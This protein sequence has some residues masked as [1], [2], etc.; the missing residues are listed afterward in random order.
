MLLTCCSIERFQKNFIFLSLLSGLPISII[1]TGER[2][3]SNDLEEAIMKNFGNLHMVFR[4]RKFIAA[5][6]LFSLFVLSGHFTTA[7]GQTRKGCGLGT[8]WDEYEVG[9]WNG[10][11]TR[12]GNSSIFDAVYKLNGEPDVNSILDISV[13]GNSV[14]IT[15]TDSPSKWAISNCSYEGKI[16]SDGVSVSGTYFC[17]GTDGTKTGSYSWNA[18]IRCG[19]VS[20]FFSGRWSGTYRNSKN[21]SGTA[22]ISFSESADGKI[23][24]DEDGVPIENVTVSGNVVWFKYKLSGCRTVEGRLAINPDGKTASGSYTVTECNGT[25]KYT[26]NY[27]DYKKQ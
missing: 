19:A 27:I 18:T 6:I 3:L 8:V 23:T 25:D 21:Q 12:R 5:T 16:S 14:N 20:K 24:G 1:F 22:Y 11:W 15:R 9:G 26:G 13:S 2:K 10:T 4:S 7:K 17:V